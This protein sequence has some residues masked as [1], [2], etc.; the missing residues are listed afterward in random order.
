MLSQYYQL[1]IAQLTQFK[2]TSMG[3]GMIAESR[4]LT[5]EELAGG[6]IK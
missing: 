3:N 5:A 6:M 2:W 4:L 1:K